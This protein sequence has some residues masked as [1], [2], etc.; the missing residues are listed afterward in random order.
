M[1]PRRATFVPLPESK[2]EV[3]TAGADL[4]KPSTILLGAEATETRFKA[5]AT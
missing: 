3:E 5:T 1:G 2:K 4:P